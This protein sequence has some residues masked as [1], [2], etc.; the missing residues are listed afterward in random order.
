MSFHVRLF[1][2]PMFTTFAELTTR[3][4][5]TFSSIQNIGRL[6]NVVFLNENAMLAY[7]VVF[8][9]TDVLNHTTPPTLSQIQ[10]I[11]M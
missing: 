3:S 1:S 4:L 2:S 7:V 8:M 6:I 5:A 10:N 9:M 11:D